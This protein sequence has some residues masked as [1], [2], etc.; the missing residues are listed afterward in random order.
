MMLGKRSKT[1][2]KIDVAMRYL[3]NRK[4]KRALIQFEAAI[5]AGDGTD[6]ERDVAAWWMYNLAKYRREWKKRRY[7]NANIYTY[8]D[9][10]VGAA[11]S[12]VEIAAILMS[13]NTR[14]IN[15]YLCQFLGRNEESIRFQ[16]RYAHG[17]P[18]KSWLSESGERYVR[19]TQ[20]KRVM[21]KLP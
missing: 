8:T 14:K 13:P 21:S 11:W 1:R 2:E 20:A 16:R 6:L 18:L 7:G 3:N 10:N 19:Y 15:N 4:V 17:H 9:E 5:R 12:D